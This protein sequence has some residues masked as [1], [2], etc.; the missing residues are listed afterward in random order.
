MPL[1][2]RPARPSLQMVGPAARATHADPS[3]QLRL[4]PS[5][6]GRCAGAEVSSKP[7]AKVIDL[8]V[9]CDHERVR[10]A[11]AQRPGKHSSRDGC[12][13]LLIVEHML[14]GP[15]SR[16]LAR[17]ATRRVANTV[18][19]KR[20]AQLARVVRCKRPASAMQTFGGTPT[21]GAANGEKHHPLWKCQAS[22]RRS[23]RRWRSHSSLGAPPE[24][25]EGGKCASTSAS[26]RGAEASSASERMQTEAG[27]GTLPTLA[28]SIPPCQAI[29]SP[30]RDCSSRARELRFQRAARHRCPV[31]RA[32][33][34][35][36][37]MPPRRE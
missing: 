26:K 9:A 36:Q 4:Q 21:Y 19:R 24:A 16:P 14:A 35:R 3:D 22:R 6:L 32:L 18:P 20:A 30:V 7:F 17:P 5:C 2:R 15:T 11:W 33:R 25:Q 1:G 8:K 12:G 10:R 23:M 13:Q 29:A 27:N 37:V 31:A 34:E 28:S